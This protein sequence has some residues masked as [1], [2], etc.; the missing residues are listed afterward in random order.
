MP[1]KRTVPQIVLLISCLCLLVTQ[2]ALAGREIFPDFIQLVQENGKA[3]VNVSSIRLVTD[4]EA[5]ELSQDAPERPGEQPFNDYFRRYFNQPPGGAPLEPVHSVGS[6]FILS[7]EG[8]VLTNAHVV[9]D[10]KSLVVRLSDRREQPAQL[11]GYDERSDVALLKIAAPDLPTVKIGNSDRLQV[12]E[13]VLAIGSPFG[14]EHTATQ[15]IVSAL[16][17]NLPS[18]SYVPFIQTDVAVNPGNSGGPLFN[19]KGEVVGINSQIYSNTGGYMGLSFAIPINVAMN[20]V[21]Q[22]KQQ[23]HV[24]RGWL[25]VLVQPVDQELAEAFGLD[26][27]RGALVTEVIDDSPAA[28]A[29]LQTGDIILSFDNRDIDET[30]RLPKFVADTPVGNTV[31]VTILREG[32][33]QQVSVAIGELDKP[34]H[35]QAPPQPQQNLQLGLALSELPDTQR[36]E[37]KLGQRGVRVEGVD[38]GPAATAGVIPGDII[39]KIEHSEVASVQGL[40]ETVAGLPSSATVPVLVQRGQ[41]PMFL[42]L[43]L[44]PDR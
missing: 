40:N 22:L 25:G 38:P 6:G 3:V 12:G 33:Q 11:I 35:A 13:W 5:A 28:A 2:S 27:P 24:T 29:K 14:L 30:G 9:K 16:G 8:Y 18:E 19:T 37:L 36:E 42:V 26:R 23:G 39:L 21:E 4:A 15:G 34:P 31:L 1:D 10:A 43:R 7:H 32:R 17:R 44:S 41:N 20:V